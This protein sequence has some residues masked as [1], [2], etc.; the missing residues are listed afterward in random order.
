MTTSAISAE[1]KS[2]LIFNQKN[3]MDKYWNLYSMELITQITT[4]GRLYH[5]YIQPSEKGRLCVC[6][7]DGVYINIIRSRIFGE[8]EI[9]FEAESAELG[10]I[11]LPSAC[12]DMQGNLDRHISLNDKT[13]VFAHYLDRLQMVYDSILALSPEKA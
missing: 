7:F 3:K 11:E 12:I 13:R 2:L 9:H 6:V 10:R 8:I 4:T 5:H 1:E